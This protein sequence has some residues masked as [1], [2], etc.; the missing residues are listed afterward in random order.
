M[1]QEEFLDSSTKKTSFSKSISFTIS[2]M[3]AKPQS[4]SQKGSSEYI[5]IE[6]LKKDNVTLMQTYGVFHPLDNPLSA[7]SYLVIQDV[8]SKR[9]GDSFVTVQHIDAERSSQQELQQE[10]VALQDHMKHYANE[11][12]VQLSVEMYSFLTYHLD[13]WLH[14]ADVVNSLTATFKA[15]A[16][17]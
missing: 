4:V 3:Q 11:R 16:A 12:Y 10:T 7:N 15:L 14:I 9:V 13:A 8:V 6:Q 5:D 2:Q 17:K 1:K